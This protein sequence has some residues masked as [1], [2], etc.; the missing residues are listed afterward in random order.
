MVLGISDSKISIGRN[1]VI[2]L[3]DRCSDVMGVKVAAGLGV[4]ET[5]GILVLH[6][7][8]LLGVLI[9]IWLVARRVEEPIVVGIFVVVASN[10]LL[11]G[12]FRVSLHMRVKQSTSV[13]HVL[14]SSAR[15]NGNLKGAITQGVASEVSLEKRAHLSIAGARV[16][17]DDEVRF[18][19][20]HVDDK[21]DSDK[22]SQAGNPVS[23]VDF[24]QPS[25]LCHSRTK[26]F[27]PQ[28]LG[29]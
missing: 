15:P 21:R 1:L 9:I 25:L 20:S 18:E 5:D 23:G 17:Q 11:A 12:S 14:E 27:R 10:L 28:T 13:T 16:F 19:G 24:L 6:K 7:S 26:Y 29:I 22:T 2:S 8:E 3:G 4:D